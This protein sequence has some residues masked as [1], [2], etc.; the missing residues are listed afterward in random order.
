MTE[1]HEQSILDATEAIFEEHATNATRIAARRRR[2]RRA[3]YDLGLTGILGPHWCQIGDDGFEFEPL[4]AR[5]ADRLA[6]ALEEL[7]RR[8]PPTPRPQPGPGQGSLFDF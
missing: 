4:S 3:L 6:Y 1:P 8:L 5:Q 2:L 7:A